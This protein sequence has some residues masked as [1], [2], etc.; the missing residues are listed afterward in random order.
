[1]KRRRQI[2]TGA[3]HSGEYREVRER[4]ETRGKVECADDERPARESR[5][6][7]ERVRD[8]KWCDWRAQAKKRLDKG[9]GKKGDPR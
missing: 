7:E 6:I 4:R 3:D 9:G 5:R 8:A 1:M 2:L